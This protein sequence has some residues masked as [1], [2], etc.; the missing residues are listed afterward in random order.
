MSKLS[1]KLSDRSRWCTVDLR[2]AMLRFDNLP[3][4]YTLVMLFTRDTDLSLSPSCSVRYRCRQVSV[5]LS[6]H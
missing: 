4:R 5:G 3:R 2:S 1:I 6:S